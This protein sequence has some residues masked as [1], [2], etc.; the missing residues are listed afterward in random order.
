MSS[1]PQDEA[2]HLLNDDVELLLDQYSS[3]CIDR[4]EFFKRAAV[5]GL[6]LSAAGKL[7]SAS[8]AN[9]A[10]TSSATMTSSARESV[11]RGGRL[12][13]GYDRDVSRLDTV[14]STFG[15][16]GL[17]AIHEPLIVKGPDGKFVPDLARSLKASKDAR[18]WTFTLR[19]GLKFQSG[20]PV[21]AQAV[22]ANLNL[23]RKVGQVGVFW[24]PVATV[25]ARGK[26]TVVVKMKAP[27]AHFP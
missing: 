8:G 17:T 27:F 4:G 7:L 16:P 25:T 15:D 13:E 22:V 19:K 18:T 12:I 5:V 11:I 14:R 2:E 1:R 24:D 20:A 10:T 6:S 9:A 3:G 26:Y 23:F 21:T